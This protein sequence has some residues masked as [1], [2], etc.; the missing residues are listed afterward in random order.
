[1]IYTWISI[2]VV[3]VCLLLYSYYRRKALLLR[4]MEWGLYVW[5]V[6]DILPHIRFSWSHS[7]I[8]GQQYLRGYSLLK[9]GLII[10]SVDRK[11]LSTWL[12]PG[13]DV[14]HAALCV[15]KIGKSG[16]Y[17][18]AEMCHIGFTKSFFYD[19]CH[20]SD[21]VLLVDCKDWDE[22]YRK[23]VVETAKGFEKTPYDYVFRPGIQALYCSE[24]VYAAD[25][26]RR[27]V[28]DTHDA[29]GVGTQ[30]VSPQDILEADN[31]Y[32]V[33]DSSG[34]LDQPN[35]EKN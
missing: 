20:T 1:M 14:S 30:Y 24:L 18:V 32:V 31:A 33:W 25:V 2:V 27:L 35:K 9:P 3:G 34:I 23:K 11:R 4:A 21:R 26:E 17:E 5:F 8:N 6:R 22:E 16:T 19:I 7:E 12:T 10:L 13:K 15:G 28:V 29:I